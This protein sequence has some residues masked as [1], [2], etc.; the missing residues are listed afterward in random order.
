MIYFDQRVKVS[1]TIVVFVKSEKLPTIEVLREGLSASDLV[2][3]EW[4][5]DS[6]EAIEGFWPALYH[7]KETG[8]EFFL[9]EIEDEDL[10][11]WDVEKKLLKGRDY[12]LM[13]DFRT[14]EE[15]AASV[16]CAAYFC[17]NFEGITFD[18]D[19]ELTVSADNCEA[20]LESYL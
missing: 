17:K 16:L 20:W 15:L 11:S 7:G 6:L 13:L 2:L 14:E 3:E 19:E 18:D 5:G 4:K 9:G 12:V 8:F 10:E 1:E